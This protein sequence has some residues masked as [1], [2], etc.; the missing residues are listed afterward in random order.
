MQKFLGEYLLF[1]L[2][3]TR[4]SGPKKIISL[5]LSPENHWTF[6]FRKEQENVLSR[7]WRVNLFPLSGLNIF[8]ISGE[9]HKEEK[10]VKDRIKLIMLSRSEAVGWFTI[11]FNVSSVSLI[12]ELRFSYPSFHSILH[13][14]SCLRPPRER[15]NSSRSKKEK[16]EENSDSLRATSLFWGCTRSLSSLLSFECESVSFWQL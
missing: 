4:F 8:T 14:S 16:E 1:H 13:H 9:R 5:S 15:E 7:E 11:T 6:L 10:R 3:S 2:L 12:L